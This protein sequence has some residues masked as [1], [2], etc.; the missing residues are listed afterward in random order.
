MDV[1]EAHDFSLAQRLKGGLAESPGCS[2]TG[3][4]DPAASSGL[5]SVAV[6]G[7]QPRQIVEALWD[8]WRIAGRAV[9][10]PPAVRF[11]T[12]IF[13]TEAEIDAVVQATRTIAREDAPPIVEEAPH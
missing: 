11:S 12:H 7:W 3:P 10:N 9:N 8:R 13:N 6:N 4:S 1:V 2:L 5:V